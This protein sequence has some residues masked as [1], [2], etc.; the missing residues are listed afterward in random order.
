MVGP[1]PVGINQFVL[2]ASAPDMNL[3]PDE[4]LIGVTVILVSC[5]YMDHPFLQV[6]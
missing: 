1:V 3:I 2:Q 5:S 4:D 6:G